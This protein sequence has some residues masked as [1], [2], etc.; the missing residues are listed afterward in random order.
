MDKPLVFKDGT[1]REVEEIVFDEP[2][3]G[4]WVQPVPRGY[5]LQCCEC[6]LVHRIDFRVVKDKRKATKRM[7]IQGS[8]YK[9][10][11][12]VYRDD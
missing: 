9:A 8:R 1:T 12:R 5:L 10:Q 3:A 7:V 2:A 6:G 4:E 11:F